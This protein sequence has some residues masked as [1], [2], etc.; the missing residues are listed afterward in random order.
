MA[1]VMRISWWQ[2]LPIF[3][4]RIV[5]VVES[6]DDIPTRLPRNGAVLVGV[7]ARPKWI[8]FDCPCRSGHRIMLN[9]DRTRLPHWV[10]KADGSLTISPSIDYTHPLRRCHYFIQK[11]R[12]RL[13]AREEREMNSTTAAPSGAV[14][15]N[16]PELVFALVGPAGVR[17]DEL[18]RIIKEEVGTFGYTSVD[19]RLSALLTNFSWE[20][21]RGT[22]EFDR[23]RHL[24]DK[25]DGL[26]ERLRDGAALA[27]AGI[28]E[29]RTQRMKITGSPDRPAAAHAYI[30][31]QLKHP[32]EVDLL[33]QVYGS[34]FLLIAGHAP[35]QQLADELAKRMARAA[36]RP[37]DDSRFQS[38]AHAIIDADQKQDGD[39]GQNTRDTY[40]KADFFANLGIPSG[41]HEVRRFVALI[42]GHPFHTPKPDEYAMYQASAVSL[43][44]SDDRRQVG[45]VIVSLTRDERSRRIKNADIIAAGMNEVPRG[46]GG[47][48]W[49]EDSPDQRD[50]GFSCG[51]KIGRQK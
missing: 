15:E 10:I 19:I 22:S 2:W 8:A 43:R 24:Q 38:N 31:R 11:G 28:A 1:D 14:A 17:L 32:D 13:G 41:E 35:R 6:A 33:R 9:A 48:Y 49:N 7:R 29:I 4:W 21:Q 47:F 37:G 5:A 39:F 44:S 34:C 36:Y 18:S 51:M 12:V 27:R 30:V 25:G 42:F 45:A 23:I 20:D 3:S 46:G 26:R 16:R 50:Q 40:P